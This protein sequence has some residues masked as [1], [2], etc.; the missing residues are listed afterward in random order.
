MLSLIPSPR[1]CWHKLP[2]LLLLM[3]F[4]SPA[5]AASTTLETADFLLPKSD[6]RL[7]R[8]L[9]LE[10]SLPVLLISDASAE[11]AGATLDLDVGSG[12]DPWEAQ[13]L[14][15]YL[16]HMLFLGTQN[17]PEIDGFQNFIAQSGGSYNAS[18]GFEHTNY[19]FE[20]APEHFAA[21]LSRFADFFLTPLFP[22][23]YSTRERNVID[24]E[25]SGGLSSDGRRYW[26]LLKE[27]ASPEHP[28]AKFNVGNKATLAGAGEELQ[29][30]L[31]GFYQQHY[32]SGR[33]RLVLYAPAGLDE[34]EQLAR[35]LFSAIRAGEAQ[36]QSSPT[37]ALLSNLPERVDY[38][39]LRELYNLS[40]NFPI[41]SQQQNWRSKSVYLLS[42]II[43][44]EAPGSLAYVLKQRQWIN[45]LHSGL[46]FDHQDSALFGVNIDLSTEGREH[47][48][49]ITALF[50]AWIQLIADEADF[51]RYFEENQQINQQQFDYQ[52]SSS[53]SSITRDLARDWHYVSDAELVAADHIFF[54]FVPEQIE[55]LLGALRPENM[56]QIVA[57]PQAETDKVEYYYQID[58]RRQAWVKTELAIDIS[59]LRLPEANRYI[60]TDLQLDSGAVSSAPEQI[61]HCAPQTQSGCLDGWHQ[62]DLSYN[63]PQTNYYFNLRN[64]LAQR[65]ARD[66]YLLD[67]WVE[68]IKE[69]LNPELYAAQIAGYDYKIYPT[70][71]GITVRLSGFPEQL[72]RVLE[73]VIS[74][75][76]HADY[77]SASF[78]RIHSEQLLNL[79][80]TAQNAPL[81]LAFESLQNQ[82]VPQS[83]TAEQ[84][85]TA[86]ADIDL[87]D[88]QQTRAGFLAT[89]SMLA[90]AH[91]NIS[92]EQAERLNSLLLAGLE[93]KAL[94]VAQV[95]PMDLDNNISSNINSIDK[96]YA[97]LVYMQAAEVEAGAQS[98]TEAHTR[99]VK[100]LLQGKFF[101]QLRTEEQ[102]GYSVAAYDYNLFE[103]PGLVFAVQSNNRDG[104]Y[105]RQRIQ[106]FI[107]DAGAYIEQ[108]DSAELDAYKQG[109]SAKIIRKPENLDR[110]SQRY[111]SFLDKQRV[112]FSYRAQ[113]AASVRQITPESLQDFWRQ[114]AQ[115]PRL[116]VTTAPI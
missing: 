9:R 40:L 15:H 45:S 53:A 64:P 8:S 42:H 52:P 23:Q 109:L 46:S 19:F 104:D 26:A 39:P 71:R 92:R 11:R 91:G 14:A 44:H 87:S 99:L 3:N 113:L 103:R 108:L 116:S 4:L 33:M 5:L 48:D 72:D 75:F 28:M 69:Q 49:E 97:A 25:Y 54:E 21:A 30:L 100:A 10:N 16:E 41:A 110:L 73:Q 82:L 86:G 112:N 17:Y 35:Q 90:L 66:R 13:G 43:G 98:N 107:A 78:A 38:K 1:A 55:Q 34:L 68:L 88:L 80:N 105:L 20:I 83:Y 60:S 32:H 18:T 58:Y 76:K 59:S 27:L 36:A 65:S 51:A 77:S 96:D 2:L 79:R 63:L 94:A 106:R 84:L 56:L 115:R 57:D 101:Q 61:L 6:Q 102:L 31:R 24:S 22:E 67:V 114:L 74:G 95:Q 111:W 12:S 93:R 7:Y 50:F 62:L 47:I 37:V 85:A 70:T 89:G 81:Q 29:A